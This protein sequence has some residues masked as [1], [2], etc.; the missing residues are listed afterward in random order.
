MAITQS[1]FEQGHHAVLEQEGLRHRA[2]KA[3]YALES[4]DTCWFE[5]RECVNHSLNDRTLRARA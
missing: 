5:L 3:P 1:V 4:L 2:L